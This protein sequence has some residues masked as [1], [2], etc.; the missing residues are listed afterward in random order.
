MLDVKLRL[1]RVI[2]DA[3]FGRRERNLAKSSLDRIEELEGREVYHW[4]E[5]ARLALLREVQNQ[6][7]DKQAAVKIDSFLKRHRIRRSS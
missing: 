2:D 5:D 6:V 3:H 7:L 1:R 4:T